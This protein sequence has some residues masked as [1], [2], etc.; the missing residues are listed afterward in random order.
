MVKYMQLVGGVGTRYPASLKTL[1]SRV[2][3]P[4]GISNN[5]RYLQ[6]K[7]Y[8]QSM[9]QN[10]ENAILKNNELL[11]YPNPATS[12]LNIKYKNNA[13]SK[14]QIINSLGVVL[15]EINLSKELQIITTQLLDV[16]PGV[17]FYK[18]IILNKTI[19]TGKLV[20]E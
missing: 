17:C 11:I 19:N 8:L 1:G 12:V 14:L 18:Q 7:T 13:D 3:H 5:N 10:F 16:P 20:I 9:H 15:Q 4:N 2:S 6:E